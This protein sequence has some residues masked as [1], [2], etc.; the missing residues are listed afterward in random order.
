MRNAGM[1]ERGVALIAVLWLVAAMGLIITGVVQAVRGEAPNRWLA[2]PSP[3]S[4]CAGRCRDLAG[5][6]KHARPKK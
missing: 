4:Q 2:T 6:S 3:R 5:A 1:T